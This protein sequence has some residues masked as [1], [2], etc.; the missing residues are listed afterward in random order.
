MHTHLQLCKVNT[1]MAVETSEFNGGKLLKYM[2]FNC[3]E[4][5][6]KTFQ[7]HF[8]LKITDAYVLVWGIHSFGNDTVSL[9]NGFWV[10]W[11]RHFKYDG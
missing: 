11:N 4:I 8:C 5:S 10:F 6:A 9:G 1:T 7:G 3:C 2:R